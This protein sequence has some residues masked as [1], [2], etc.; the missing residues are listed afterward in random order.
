[1]QKTSFPFEFV[2]GEDC[3]T[4]GTREIVL[5]YAKRYPGIIRVI[6]SGTNVG[7]KANSVRTQLA[8]QGEYI[9]YCEGDDYWI[10]P[11]KLQKQ[12]EAII[13]YGAVMVTHSTFVVFYHDGKIDFEPKIRR[14][15]NESGFLDIKE[16][17]ESKAL[18]HT[19]S[20]FL[21][22]DILKSLPDWYD[23]APVGD[24]PIKVISAYSGKIYFIDEIMSVY[25]KGISGSYTERKRT[26]IFQEDGWRAD[27][28]KDFLQMY[29]NID[30]Y[31]KYQYTDL[32]RDVIK[33][34]LLN[35]YYIIG[36]LDFLP[37][38]GL[39]KKDFK[40]IAVL[41]RLLPQGLQRK[42]LR[43]IVIRKIGDY[44]QGLE[45][46]LDYKNKLGSL[47]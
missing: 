8:C 26:S 9:A 4:D 40:R 33:G 11:L 6:T 46:T 20:F 43:K 10:D 5:D 47:Q 36:N 37:S 27:H 35:Y 38:I 3:S 22:S 39:Q 17:L 28:E 31:T 12:Y 32:I 7:G 29:R 23:Q 41:V 14:A 16:I 44:L 13:K 2:I 15:R 21:R 24:L 1:M 42:V 30:E 19:S 25:C 45:G 18:I 34:R